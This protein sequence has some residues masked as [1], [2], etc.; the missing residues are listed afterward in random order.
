[1]KHYK[2]RYPVITAAITAALGCSWSAIAAEAEDAQAQE[3]AAIERII[4]T[5]RNKEELINKIPVA[6]SAFSGDDIIKNSINSVED[7]IAQTPGVTFDSTGSDG[8]NGP[9]IRGLA[10]P[11]LVGDETNVAV[12]ID[13]V[14]AS[15]REAAFIPFSGLERVEVVRGPQSAIYGRNAFAG[16]INYITKGT[17]DELTGGFNVTLGTDKMSKVD[18]NLSAPISDKLGFRLDAARHDS[19]STI[20]NINHITGDKIDDRLLGRKKTD[21]VNAKLSFDPTDDI[22]IVLGHAYTSSHETPRATAYI[23]ANAGMKDTF[24]GTYYHL[25]KGELNHD[26]WNSNFTGVPTAATGTDQEVNRTTFKFDYTGEDV[27]FTYLAGFNKS[28]YRINVGQIA[29][30]DGMLMMPTALANIYSPVNILDVV[31]S[32]FSAFPPQ[33]VYLAQAPF[34][35][36]PTLSGMAIGPSLIGTFAHGYDIGGQPNK[37]RKEFSHEVRLSGDI[38]DVGWVVGG[39]YSKL[40]LDDWLHYAFV[41]VTTMTQN[42]PLTAEDQAALASFLGEMQGADGSLPVRKFNNYTTKTQSAFFSLDYDFLDDFNITAEGR[43]TKEE[44]TTDNTV[45]LQGPGSETGYQS[46]DWSYFTPRV[47]VDYDLNESSLLYANVG[48]GVKSGGFNGGAM[49]AEAK[50]EP[51]ENWTYELGLKSFVM[52]GMVKFNLAAYFIDWDK[53]QIRTFASNDNAQLSN[54]VANLGK[55]EVKGIEF[56]SRVQINDYFGWNLA[57]AYNDAKVKEG[58]VQS[59]YGYQ[60]TENFN[61]ET[62][63]TPIYAYPAPGAP[64]VGYNSITNGDISGTT[65]PRTSKWTTNSSLDYNQVWGETTSFAKLIFGYRSSQFLDNTNSTELPGVWS[66]KFTGGIERNGYRISFFVDNLLNEDIPTAG[67]GKYIWN[68]KRQNVIEP[69]IGRQAGI[70]F[71][72]QF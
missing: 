3:D 63:D 47:T 17:A 45:G 20:E 59:E 67:Y 52:D 40:N 53:Q 32:D 31:N 70:S 2:V 23:D 35:G 28:K 49:G 19:G 27:N 4:V 60:D 61:M 66:S 51:E 6:V 42:G 41:P 39:F 9:V 15:G 68:G 43:Y 13:G 33:M 62:I 50:F 36:A 37:D 1:M 72:Y 65:M 24:V 38:G 71:A 12:F 11:G 14:Y 30:Q 64:I 54:I 16:A 55:T 18:L 26:L 8:T 48:K 46:G 57:V 25:Y 29:P 34:P 69:R 7:V 44:K 21:T 22:N 58:V 10:Q 5:S 56:D